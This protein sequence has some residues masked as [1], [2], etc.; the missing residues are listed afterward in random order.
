MIKTLK[1]TAMQTKFSTLA[2]LVL[3]LFCFTIVSCSKDSNVNPN[4]ATVAA[5]IKKYAATWD[6]IMNKGKL[7][8][9]NT[10]NFDKNMVFHAL[11]SNI[12]GIDSAKAYYGAYLTGFSN[13]EFTIVDIFGQGDKLTKHWRFK[14]VHTGDFFGIAPT[15]KTVSVDGSTISTMENG[16]IVEE[17][18][19]STTLNLCSNLA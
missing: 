14:G 7:D 18:D 1:L 15:G 2:T 13:I 19:F 11:P 5:N 16:I 12:V 10:S 3:G 4:D 6:A 8:I 17:Q 9:F